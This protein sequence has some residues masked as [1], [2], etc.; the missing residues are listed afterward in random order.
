[1][2]EFFGFGSVQ[3]RRRHFFPGKCPAVEKSVEK[4]VENAIPAQALRPIL[5]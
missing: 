2:S 5:S 3:N 1:M 4:S